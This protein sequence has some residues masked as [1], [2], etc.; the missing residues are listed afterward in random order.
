MKRT[1]TRWIKAS[2][3]GPAATWMWRRVAPPPPPE[4]PEN[5]NET[6]YAFMQHVL[7]ADSNCVDIGASFGGYLKQMVVIAPLGRHH[8]FEPIPQLAEDLKRKFPSAH[9]HPMALSDHSGTAKFHY[10]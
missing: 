8:A 3:L 2:P 1:L 4:L 6:M 10:F 5:A 9:I 7:R